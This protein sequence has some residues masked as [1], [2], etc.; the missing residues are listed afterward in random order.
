MTVI[1]GNLLGRRS[2]RIGST[3]ALIIF[4]F[5]MTV[6]ARAFYGSMKACKEG[7]THMR[8]GETVRAVTFFDRAI[9]WYTP[10]NP[11][12]ERSAEKLWEIGERAQREGDVRLALM[13]V[14]A[15]RGGFYSARS[16]YT[17]GKDWI[18]KAEERI[19][20]LEQMEKVDKGLTAEPEE[21]KPLLEESQEVVGPDPG[22]SAVVVL[23]FLGWVGSVLLFARSWLGRRNQGKARLLK[24]GVWLGLAAVLYAIWIVGMFRA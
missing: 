3:I 13:A 1:G 6:W 21:G 8:Q 24:G 18:A 12:V 23:S 7:E 20:E 17:P 19:K 22:W 5:L 4:V 2:L 9:H 10:L 16:L 11:Y 14:R 15:I